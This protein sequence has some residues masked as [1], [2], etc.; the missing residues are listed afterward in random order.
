MGK[1][2]LSRARKM[3][4]RLQRLQ[5]R[6]QPKL[7]RLKKRKELKMN[8]KPK[9]LEKSIPKIQKKVKI[10][11]SVPESESMKEPFK[12]GEKELNTIYQNIRSIPNFSAK[13][14]DFLRQNEIH[15]KYRR[16]VKHKFPRRRIIVNYP[17]QIFMSDLIEYSQSGMRFA[18]QGY[19]YILIFI[20]CFTRKVFARPLKKKNAIEMSQ[21]INSILND[22]ENYPNSIITDE[23]LE[24]Y[25]SKVRSIFANHAIH[26]YSI[27][28][29]MKASIV[30]RFNRTIKSRFE[31][32]FDAYKTKKW[33]DVLQDFIANYNRTYHRSIGMS[34]DEVTDKNSKQVFEKLYPNIHLKVVPRLSV[35]DRVRILKEKTIFE[36]G[37][38]KSWSEE[39]YRIRK[40]KQLAGRVW[41]EIETL[42]SEKVPGI[43]YYWELNLIKRKNDR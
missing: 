14:N 31:K 3:K 19:V 17:Y 4:T 26:H 36:K 28:T 16:I 38:S 34:P 25:N 13:I 27:K 33:I 7:N 15:S 42:N 12:D 32:Y 2:I 1:E 41:Y 29:K 22:L 18:N 23:G 11:K 8:Q 24:Y 40:V 37:Y 9:K 10:V 39:I 21:A 20:D 35:G 6:L 43:K 30:E 5:E